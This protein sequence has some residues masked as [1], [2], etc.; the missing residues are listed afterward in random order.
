[1]SKTRELLIATA[2]LLILVIIMVVVMMGGFLITQGL[3]RVG[4][5][6]EFFSYVGYMVMGIST[7][8][9]L[10]FGYVIAKRLFDALF[11]K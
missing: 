3:M 11:S 5:G 10:G 6:Y 4:V 7:G 8:I 1:M 9:S 2:S